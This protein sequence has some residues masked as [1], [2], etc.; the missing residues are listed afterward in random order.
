MLDRRCTYHLCSRSALVRAQDVGRRKD[1]GFEV[2]QI[3]KFGKNFRSGPIV[4]FGLHSASRSFPDS[5]LQKVLFFVRHQHHLVT[6]S[7]HTDLNSE[8]HRSAFAS[9]AVMSLAE[10][11]QQ[12]L[13]SLTAGHE[14]KSARRS[15]SA[16]LPSAEAYQVVTRFLEPILRQTATFGTKERRGSCSIWPRE[17]RSIRYLAAMLPRRQAPRWTLHHRLL[18]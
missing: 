3:V 2:E 14:P 5:T 7:Y 8:R 4:K 12:A 9:S 13:H 16:Q 11:W 18:F 1:D 15:T 6:R 10:T 17:R